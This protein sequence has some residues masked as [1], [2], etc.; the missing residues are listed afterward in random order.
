MKQ[1]KAFEFRCGWESVEEVTLKV[2]AF[3]EEL[4]NGGNYD[5][6]IIVTSTGKGCVYNVIYEK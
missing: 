4:K 5:V 1:V 6:E 2:N 3:V